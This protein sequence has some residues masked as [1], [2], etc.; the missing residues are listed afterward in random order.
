MNND[1]QDHIPELRFPQFNE[2]WK[3]VNLNELLS[4][5]NGFN[6]S[7]EDYGT[8]IKFINVSDI[9]ENN[10]LDYESIDESV[11]VSEDVKE[12][13]LVEYGDIVFQRS[14][15]TREDV[16]SANVYLDEEPCI[17]GGFVIR[18]KKINEYDPFFLKEL[19]NTARVRR[20]ITSWSGG[21]T[22]YNIG[23]DSLNKISIFIPLIEEQKKVASFLSL[24]DKKIELL[25]KKYEKYEK[26]KKHYLNEIF[27]SEK[28]FNQ[29]LGN[30]CNI[31][32]G[33]LDANA[34]VENGKYRFF[35]CAKEYYQ[36]DS[37]EFDTE[38]L[39][40]SGNGAN[41]GYIHYYNGKFNAYQRTY[42]LD[43]FDEN[44]EI[45]YI[46]YFLEKNL[47]KQIWKEKK[48][49]NTPYIVLSTLRDMQISFPDLDE[50]KKIKNLF[51][52]ID[53]KMNLINYEISSF[54]NF[55]KGLLQKMFI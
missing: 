51:I 1:N 26:I 17:F 22:R 14:S 43:N 13:Y 21:S 33:K 53:K 42:V 50:Q 2:P 30:L 25:E 4:F 48:E 31:Q 38:A 19:L 6:G 45:K 36:I 7:R 52:N 23:Q 47:Q 37:Y 55:K 35:T 27:Q 15:E 5:K 3:E 28:T 40:I 8:G 49:G 39:L 24:I 10:F 34:M 12:N 54:N 46:K 44:V 18:G 9:L 16:G 41:V 29:N 11:N 32:T 20:E